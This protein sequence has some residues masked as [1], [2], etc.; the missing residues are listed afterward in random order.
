[1]PRVSRPFATATLLAFVACLPAPAARG[2]VAAV[3]G[4][5]AALGWE[6]VRASGDGNAIVSPASVWETLAMTH[7]GARG[8]TAA[9]IAHVLGMPDDREQIAASAADLRALVAEAKGEKIRLDIA[10]RIWVERTQKLEASFTGLLQARYAAAAGLVDFMTRPEDA[11][12]QINTWV[13]EHTAG[14]IPELLPSGSI[15]AQTRI[16]LTNAVYLKA[17]WAKPFEKSATQPAAFTVAGGDK[18]QVP[19]MNWSGKLV[20]GKV[21]VGEAAATVCE[22]PYE[23]GRLAMV[24]VV[25]DVADGLPR[26]LGGLDR[27]WRA[28][29]NDAGVR[30]REV[31]L[32]LPRGDGHEAGVRGRRG[33]PL[34]HRRRP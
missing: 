14:K 26:T 34:R 27:D 33:G 10:N 30:P 28:Q 22:I 20:A 15:T 5:L 13:G 31:N 24:I 18:P 7:A 29:W 19:F 11:R 21:V 12:T 32:A 8:E 16:V 17:P 9:E 23:G 25:P 4:G 2:D 6:L 1:M 3:A